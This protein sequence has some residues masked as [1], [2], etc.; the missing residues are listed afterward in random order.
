MHDKNL[1]HDLYIFYIETCED[2][3]HI[4]VG[5]VH[6]VLSPDCPIL[7]QIFDN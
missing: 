4:S 1:P 6:T 2:R 3:D 7:K 5:H